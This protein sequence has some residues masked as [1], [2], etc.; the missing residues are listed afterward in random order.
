LN[1]ED[2]SMEL[3]RMQEVPSIQLHARKSLSTSSCC[4]N[5][6][7]DWQ[8]QLPIAWCSCTCSRCQCEAAV[9]ASS[10]TTAAQ[11]FE[12]TQFVIADYVLMLSHCK[13]QTQTVLTHWTGLLACHP[14]GAP[15]VVGP[16]GQANAFKVGLF[17]TCMQCMRQCCTTE[18]TGGW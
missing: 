14:L 18:T 17:I 7:P 15:G 6:P 9:K 4:A 12:A 2:E 11:R 3:Q 8:P 10:C 16:P 13:L 1:R 5:W